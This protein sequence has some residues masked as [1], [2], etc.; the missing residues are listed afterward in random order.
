MRQEYR[1]VNLQ[2]KFVAD[3]NNGKSYDLTEVERNL[4]ML[5]YLSVRYD[6]SIRTYQNNKGRTHS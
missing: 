5:H 6:K 4:K 1:S 2:E 3:L